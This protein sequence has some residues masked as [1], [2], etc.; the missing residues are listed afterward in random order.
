MRRP[1]R[2]PAG[3]EE[4][5]LPVVRDALPLPGEVAAK[6]GCAAAQ[7]E[8]RP[9]AR[10]SET[11]LQG[12]LPRPRPHSCARAQGRGFSLLRF[13]AC[14]TLSDRMRTFGNRSLNDKTLLT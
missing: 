5:A 14:V 7:V 10:S 4:Q 13:W 1:L 11:E 12:N 3:N 6:P 8:A 2:E 9:G